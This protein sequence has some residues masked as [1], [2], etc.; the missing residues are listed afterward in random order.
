MEDQKYYQ[1]LEYLQGNW[2]EKR[3]YKEWVEQF[4]EK[5]GQIYQEE[6]RIISRSQV[7]KVISIFHDLLTAAY[8]SKDA[9]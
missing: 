1:L 2:K 5:G 6:R 4:Y 7:L 3:E 9:V 8:Q